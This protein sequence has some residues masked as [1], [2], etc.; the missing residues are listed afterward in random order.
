MTTINSV[1]TSV[2]SSKNTKHLWF[3]IKDKIGVK[4]AV[5]CRHIARVNRETLPNRE[6]AA[7]FR[8]PIDEDARTDEDPN[9]DDPARED[10]DIDVKVLTHDEQHGQIPPFLDS[11][12]CL[13]K[14]GAAKGTCAPAY[15]CTLLR[16]KVVVAAEALGSD[17]YAGECVDNDLERLREGKSICEE[18]WSSSKAWRGS[19]SCASLS[20]LLPSIRVSCCCCGDAII[21]P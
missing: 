4:H 14:R 10:I 5:I 15:P 18:A 8:N 12:R 2:T 13:N 20:K 9:S 6:F 21:P 11:E 17:E 7:G 3:A 1:T 16:A 19:T